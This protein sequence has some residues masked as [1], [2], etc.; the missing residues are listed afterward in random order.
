MGFA[1]P[2]ELVMDLFPCRRFSLSITQ[3]PFQLCAFSLYFALPCNEFF[4]SLL[5]RNILLN[6]VESPERNLFNSDAFTL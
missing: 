4:F 2:D 6:I 3:N 5:N 1:P